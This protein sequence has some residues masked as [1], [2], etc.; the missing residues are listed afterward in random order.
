MPSQN[1]TSIGEMAESPCDLAH[2]RSLSLPPPD[3]P[4]PDRSWAICGERDEDKFP[5]GWLFSHTTHVPSF[6][7]MMV[8][9]CSTLE[10]GP[11]C[12]RMLMGLRSMFV[13]YA[14]RT[15]L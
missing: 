15:D 10:F 7:S 14:R 2:M 4:L 12:C 5:L 13:F 11:W 9:N 6:M 1:L 8:F 3:P